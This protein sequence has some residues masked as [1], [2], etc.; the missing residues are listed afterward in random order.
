MGIIMCLAYAFTVMLFIDDLTDVYYKRR[1]Y[2]KSFWN[3]YSLANHALMLVGMTGTE[4][5]Q[6]RNF[7]TKYTF[8]NG[9]SMK[10]WKT[11]TNA[12]FWKIVFSDDEGGARIKKW[13]DKDV[14]FSLQFSHFVIN[15]NWALYQITMAILMLNI[16]IAIMNTTYATMWARIDTEWKFSKSCYKVRPD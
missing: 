6:N 5:Q 16:L 15:A 10:T 13:G 4:H 3:P 14:D 7:T 1:R 11:L 12:Y 2:I 9:S 8:V